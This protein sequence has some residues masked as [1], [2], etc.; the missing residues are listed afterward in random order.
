MFDDSQ[1]DAYIRYFRRTSIPGARTWVCY[2]RSLARFEAAI[3]CPL[4]KA[5]PMQLDDLVSRFVNA[6]GEVRGTARTYYATLQGFFR[7]A[8]LVGICQGDPLATIPPP[9]T[10]PSIPRYLSL[11]GIQ[12]VL[13]APVSS[14]PAGVMDRALLSTMYGCGLRIS[15][16][17]NLN[18]DHVDMRQKFLVVVNGKGGKSR[19]IPLPEGTHRKLASWLE[20]RDALPG[21]ESVF[22]L[23]RGRRRITTD[24]IR[25]RVEWAFEAAGVEGTPHALRHS[26]ATHHLWAGSNLVEIQQLMGHATIA[27]TM[28]YTHVAPEQFRAAQARIA[29]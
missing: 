5:T 1:I 23:A 6:Q 15:E 7:W 21:E 13:A 28:I 9:R 16:A 19:G 10:V 11:D 25:D 8:K 22:L 29:A 14:K 4:H 20:V 18:L 26:F 17:C 2:T 27:S 12:R 3:G 24:A